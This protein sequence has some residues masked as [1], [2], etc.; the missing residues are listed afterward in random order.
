MWKKILIG[1]AIVLGLVV[2]GGLVLP[3]SYSVSRSTTVAV[4]P[5]SLQPLLEDLLLWR[6]WAP[7]EHMDSTIVTTM[8]AITR[9]LDA[10]QSWTDKSGGGRL[11]ITVCQ[12]GRVEY[13]V[14]FGK[15][16]APIHSI[17]TAVPEGAGC[18]VDWSMAGEMDMPV[19]GPY[20]AM[21]ADRMIGPMFQQG[22]DS[23][24][25]VVERK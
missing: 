19:V 22:L 17:L 21:L 5:D 6:T 25:A 24:K 16:P 11:K 20:F 18:R 13:D 8:G 12:P 9:G 2:V 10:E 4:A 15:N 23:L 3:D 1:L 14:W 7:W